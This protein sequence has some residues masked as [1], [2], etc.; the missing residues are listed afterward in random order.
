MTGVDPVLE[1]DRLAGRPDDVRRPLASLEEL[2]PDDDLGYRLRIFHVTEDAL[3]PR[4]GTLSPSTM[5]AHFRAFFPLLGL[6]EPTDDLLPRIAE[7][8]IVEVNC[9]GAQA[10]L[11]PPKP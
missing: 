5:R 6:A 1:W 4:G 11:L 10:T 7:K 2:E 9:T 3:P 8:H